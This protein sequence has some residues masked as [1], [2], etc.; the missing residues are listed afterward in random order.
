MTDGPRPDLNQKATDQAEIE[1][2]GYGPWM[3]VKRKG[4]RIGPNKPMGDTGPTNRFSPLKLDQEE[5]ERN[6]RRERKG[7]GKN[8]EQ[9]KMGP[10]KTSSNGPD[11]GLVRH[12]ETSEL[13]ND[14]EDP[15][16]F[17]AQE[18]SQGNP[19][20]GKFWSSSEE[21]DAMDTEDHFT[22]NNHSNGSKYRVTENPKPPKVPQ[23][24]PPSTNYFLEDGPLN[25]PPNVATTS[26]AFPQPRPTTNKPPDIITYGNSTSTKP[27]SSPSDGIPV[28]QDK[29]ERHQNVQHSM[30]E[31]EDQLENSHYGDGRG[32]EILID[33]PNRTRSGLS[34]SAAFVCSST[35][36][37]MDVADVNFPKKE[38]AQLTCVCERHIGTQ[39]GGMDQAISVMAQPDFAELIDFNPI[40]ATDVQLPAGGSFVIAHSLAE[41]Q[42]AVTAATNYN[43]R[44]VECR[45][46]AVSSHGSS[47]PAVVVKE[48]LNEEP[49]TAADIEKI[50]EEK[51]H[52]VFAD[53]PS[54]LDVLNAAKH[55]KLFQRASHVYS[56]AKRVYAFKD[57]VSSD[58]RL[59]NLLLAI[60]RQA[61]VLSYALNLLY[62]DLYAAPTNENR[63]QEG[64]S[65]RDEHSGI[66]ERSSMHPPPIDVETLDD[67]IISSPR[68]FA[69]MVT[70]MGKETQIFAVTVVGY[71]KPWLPWKSCRDP[72]GR[73]PRPSLIVRW[74][75]S[76]LRKFTSSGI[77][78]P[79]Y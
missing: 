47:D 54:S 52:L 37:I 22:G 31:Q 34:S 70:A 76:D 62:L 28:T 68:A 21:T 48:L 63:D 16:V 8:S 53:S 41:S 17:Q 38:I 4:R 29:Q 72:C 67:V 60:T 2:A 51:L 46:A 19:I 77:P 57:T 27:Q 18:T 7:Q 36:A 75:S 32:D 26:V 30:V 12:A 61:Q 9:Q 44:V 6:R 45:L 50:T 79:I 33:P 40:H 56:E 24:R 73:W 64:T 59:I 3:M 42:K 66:Q 11:K 55:F 10:N 43:N 65:V 25:S 78:I 69:E 39:S 5:T 58:L 35:I 23:R 20:S 13:S 49:Y 1:G 15:I 14:P 74:L 71:A